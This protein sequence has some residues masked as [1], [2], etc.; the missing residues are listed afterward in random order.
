MNCGEVLQRMVKN[1]VE[2]D[3]LRDA[4]NPPPPPVPL[5]AEHD[6]ENLRFTVHHG[7]RK[8]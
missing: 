2:A 8:P 3:A 7:E 6:P 5:E 1:K 4:L